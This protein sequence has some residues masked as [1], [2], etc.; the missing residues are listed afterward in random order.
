[1]C[2]LAK[3]ITDAENLPKVTPQ[4]QPI[5]EWYTV[6]GIGTKLPD[7]ARYHVSEFGEGFAYKGEIITEPH[8]TRKCLGYECAGNIYLYA[9]S[10]KLAGGDTYN[11]HHLLN[12][13]TGEVILENIAGLI[14]PTDSEGRYMLYWK[15]IPNHENDEIL[16]RYVF[17]LATGKTLEKPKEIP[18]VPANLK[19][20]LQ[21]SPWNVRYAM[22]VADLE[23][24]RQEER[25]AREQKARQA[26]EALLKRGTQAWGV[27]D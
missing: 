22:S 23:K 17:D 2:N 4:G 5:N 6:Q 25:M 7:V 11:G 12:A 27:I 15:V 13:K 16:Y 10:S 24:K 1:M 9:Y 20:L 8:F 3:K 26:E 14:N 19:D 21:E 18:D